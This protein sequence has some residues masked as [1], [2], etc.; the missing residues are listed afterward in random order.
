MNGRQSSPA[1]C[2]LRVS[3]CVKITLHVLLL[4]GSFHVH[5]HYIYCCSFLP[6]LG[7][8]AV[9]FPTPLA[10]LPLGL[11]CFFF[12][13]CGLFFFLLYIHWSTVSA[14]CLCLVPKSLELVYLFYT[15]VCHYFQYLPKVVRL[16][17]LFGVICLG[18][19]LF[20]HSL[21]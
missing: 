14:F 21:L 9:L 15:S 19:D 10:L 6:E 18:L 8:K 20:Q 13:V 1:V 2:F 3:G 16:P 12:F 5:I 11:T 7:F 4:I 17:L